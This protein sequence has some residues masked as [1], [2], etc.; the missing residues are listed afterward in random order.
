MTDNVK[1]SELP[2]LEDRFL[3]PPGWRWHQFKNAKGRSLRF[4]SV[5]PENRVPEAIVIALEGLSEFSEKYFEVAH[6]LLKMDC[7]FWVLDWQGQGK[8][9]RH[10]KNPHKR[11]SSSF[12]EDVADLHFFIQEYVKH[13]AVHPDVGR[14]PLVMLGHSM[15]ANIGLHYLHRHPDMVTWPEMSSWLGLPKS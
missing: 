2:D 9:Q 3:P 10:L 1:K 13:S 4:G 7:A 12:D 15:G 11:H 14:I 5:F 8:S 6:D